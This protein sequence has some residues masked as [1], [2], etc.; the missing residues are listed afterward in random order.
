MDE[1][2][3]SVEVCIAKNQILFIHGAT[4]MVSRL[5]EGEYPNYTQ[6]IPSATPFSFVLAKDDFVKAVKLSGIFAS[7]GGNSV[8]LALNAKSGKLTISSTTTIGEERTQFNAAITGEGE[9]KIVFDYRYLLDGLSVIETDEVEF[10]ASTESAPAVMKPHGN[11]QLLYIV[12][13]IRQ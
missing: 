3:E 7:S 11:A 9:L 10:G 6:I 1:E 5:I 12:M 13:P 4:E 2:D 8:T